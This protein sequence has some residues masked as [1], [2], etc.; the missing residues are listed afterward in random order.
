[1]KQTFVSSYNSF[2]MWSVDEYLYFESYFHL[3]VCS[4]KWW[5]YSAFLA[6]YSFICCVKF[7]CF[8]YFL[9]IQWPRD[10]F[11]KKCPREKR[12]ITINKN[13]LCV[14]ERTLN[15][16]KNSIFHFWYTY[17]ESSKYFQMFWGI[18]CKYVLLAAFGLWINI[19]FYI[20]IPVTLWVTDHATSLQELSLIKMF[21][22]YR[23]QTWLIF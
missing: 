7:S 6:E 1:M 16:W 17:Y 12:K 21:L 13:N 14:V 4:K 22:M 20:K 11:D 10:K 2:N 19:S 23:L 8:V 5:N 18:D 15:Y 3:T 9:F